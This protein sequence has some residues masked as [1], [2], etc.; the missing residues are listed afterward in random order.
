[1]II[2]EN[3][4]V[5]GLIFWP[6]DEITAAFERVNSAMGKE[7]ETEQ[8]RLF[9]RTINYFYGQARETQDN[10]PLQEDDVQELCR[11]AKKGLY[12]ELGIT[13]PEEKPE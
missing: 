8:M 9:I 12:A 10:S 13:A 4:Q 2:G 6:E 7:N 5:T 11:L 3:G 1:M